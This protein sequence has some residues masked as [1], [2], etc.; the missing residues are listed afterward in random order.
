MEAAPDQPA[1]RG[2]AR[3]TVYKVPAHNDFPD[4]QLAARMVQTESGKVVDLAL[5]NRQELPDSS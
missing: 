2:S 5:V 4:V 3:R 1:D